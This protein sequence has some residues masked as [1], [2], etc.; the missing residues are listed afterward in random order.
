M[1]RSC[2]N[3]LKIYHAKK[4]SESETG[5]RQH[6]AAVDNLVAFLLNSF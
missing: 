5:K 3:K 2:Q 4:V 6:T 1:L